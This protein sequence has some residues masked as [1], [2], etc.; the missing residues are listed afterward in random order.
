MINWKGF[1]KKPL[2]PN[3]K[4]LSQHFSGGTEKDTKTLS[5]NS[6]SA[7][8]DLNL[9]PPKYVNIWHTYFSRIYYAGRYKTTNACELV[10]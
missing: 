9:G 8:P 4:I 1:V 3:F 5:Q 10:N 7:G 2:W 6:R